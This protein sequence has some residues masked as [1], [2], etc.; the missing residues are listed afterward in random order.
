MARRS[1]SQ[2]SRILLYA[3][4][5]VVALSMV[6]SLVSALVPRRTPT[7]TP[8]PV[9]TAIPRLP[10]LTPRHTTTPRPTATMTVAAAMPPSTTP[11]PTATA[12]RLAREQATP[13]AIS[14]ETSFTFAVCGD[15]RGGDAVYRRILDMVVRDGCA[16]LIN[17]GD[18]VS[19][20]YD[21]QFKAFRDLMKDF[22]L[23]FFPVPGNHDSPNGLLT[24]YLEYSGAPAVHYSFDYGEVHFAVANTTLG[25]I[26]SSELAWLDGDLAA[27]DKPV[28]IVCLHY[29][30]FDPAGTTHIMRSGNE[31]FMALMTERGVKYVFAGHIHSYDMEERAGVTYIITGGA[32]APLYPE[33][34]REAFYH[35]IRV[36]V[37]GEQLQTEV[38]RV[39]G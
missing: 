3:I 5:V 27:T 24:E 8:T 7:L 39:A 11:L 37:R 21:Y 32:G 23:P 33:E 2:Q 28:K 38:V 30:P 16:F 19:R 10:T 12:T 14:D 6:C 15:N 34:N 36:T 9:P 29:P 17:T 25:E 4:A 22:P 13:I 18:L 31:D 35:Y 1:K 20:G 26:G